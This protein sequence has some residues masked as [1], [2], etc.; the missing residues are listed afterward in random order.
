MGV[1]HFD[2]IAGEYDA[3]LPSHVRE[4]YLRR[5]ARFLQ[6]AFAKAAS[7]RVEE[8]IS[9]L[10]VGCGTGSLIEAVANR[11]AVAGYGV[12][13]SQGMLLIARDKR[14]CA[15]VRASAMQL[16]FP[17]GT[18]DETFSIALLHHLIQ[19]D[20]VRAAVREM[21]RVT[22][23]G[24]LVV[25]WDHNPANPYWP[26]IMKKVPQDTGEERLVPAD[27]V[28]GALQGCG[29]SAPR[30]LKRGFVPEFAPKVLMPLAVLFE[31]I[32]EITPV[33]R[34]LS[35]H[36]VI[37]ATKDATHVERKES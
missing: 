14:R 4:H 2:K 25:I 3:S 23:P 10:D 20:A 26:V 22:R 27:E 36:N 24:G 33:V 9:F 29:V 7:A 35:A 5:R 28:V 31:R 37:I 8:T 1:E 18:F 13:F 12:D 34:R 15:V 6:K 16:P 11:R 21:V 19:P 30:V 17:D 32:A